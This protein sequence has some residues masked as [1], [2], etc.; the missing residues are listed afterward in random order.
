[1]TFKN[2]SEAMK[3]YV[4]RFGGW[5]AFIIGCQSDEVIIPMVEKALAEDK[6][7]EFDFSD[8]SIQY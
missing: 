7:F 2:Q 4:E 3:A 8:P 1:M 5:P 6:P